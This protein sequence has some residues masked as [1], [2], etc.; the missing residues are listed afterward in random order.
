MH[1]GENTEAVLND[2]GI[3][4]EKVAVLVERGIII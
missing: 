3:P 2:W 1:P 4:S